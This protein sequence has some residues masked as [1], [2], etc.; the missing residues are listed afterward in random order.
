[1]AINLYEQYAKL[2][3]LGG[4]FAARVLGKGVSNPV[5]A[6]TQKSLSIGGKVFPGGYFKDAARLKSV[7]SG[8]KTSSNKRQSAFD[9]FLRIGMAR[10][11][12]MGEVFSSQGLALIVAHYRAMRDG[13][14]Q[15]DAEHAETIGVLV[16][17]IQ[18]LTGV[19]LNEAIVLN[20]Q[21]VA[22]TRAAAPD[23][24]ELEAFLS[25]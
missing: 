20:S 9:A 17:A 23:D 13:S 11:A 4:V 2:A 22:A 21:T 19:D 25:E 18:R 12:F 15:F 8:E 14:L 24:A 1:M 10:K 6:L 16:D 7:L 5:Q 3:T